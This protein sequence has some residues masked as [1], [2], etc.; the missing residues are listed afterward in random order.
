LR[1]TALLSPRG[2]TADF[3]DEIESAGPFGQGAPAPRFAFPAQ[4]IK[5]SMIIGEGHLKI[6]F[7]D[8]SGGPAL[9]AMLFQGAATPLG[10]GLLGAHQS[11][12]L[13]HIAGRLELNHWQ[14]RVKVQMRLEDAAKAL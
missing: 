14:G 4:R 10:Q 1:V 8:P 13:W 9:E 2:A 12:D 11:H 3:I 6:S 5:S 7:A